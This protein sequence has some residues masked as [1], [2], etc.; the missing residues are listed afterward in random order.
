[1]PREKVGRKGKGR[2]QHVSENH[3]G[4]RSGGWRGDDQ[5]R[6][7]SGSLPFKRMRH[8]I[9]G[10]RRPRLGHHRHHR[11]HRLGEVAEVI[12]AVAIRGFGRAMDL[13]NI[14]RRSAQGHLET[15]PALS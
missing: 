10:P 8:R 13:P 7:S 4:G 2:D 1:M 12:Q 9:A 6:A 15:F 11:R 5:R 14:A 3:Y